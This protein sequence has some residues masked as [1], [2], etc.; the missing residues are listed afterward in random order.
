MLWSAFIF[1]LLG[2]FHCVGMCGAIALSIPMNISTRIALV[3]D[4]L[5]YNFGRVVMYSI[6]GLLAG[7]FG[8]TFVSLGY[9]QWLSLV[10]GLLIISAFV[11]PTRLQDNVL[12]HIGLNFLQK[13]IRKLFGKFI[14]KPT[15]LN[16][17]FTGILNGM[18]PCG[19]VY[20]ALAGAVLTGDWT[21]SMLYMTVFGLG[22]IP[23]MAITTLSGNLV[24]IQF[25]N[26]IK[27]LKPYLAILVAFLFII[28]GLSL[29]IP[30]LSPKLP[31]PHQTEEVCG[32]H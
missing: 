11:I 1:G 14:T 29:G 26:K 8:R 5:F 23:M 31:T 24:T 2:S 15:P 7:I 10:V 30:Y 20:I 17:L 25:R 12:Q 18:L 16:L 27:K 13:K 3:K 28:R 22:T 4:T 32:T 21:D 9:Q 6:I 19:F